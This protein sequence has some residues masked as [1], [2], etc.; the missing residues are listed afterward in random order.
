MGGEIEEEVDGEAKRG[1]EGKEGKV[2][3]EGGGGEAGALD[4]GEDE[5]VGAGKAANQTGHGDEGGVFERE[6]SLSTDGVAVFVEEVM[7]RDGGEEVEMILEIQTEPVGAG[8]AGSPG[9]VVG[10]FDDEGTVGGEEGFEAAEVLFGI[11]EVFEDVP[12]SDDVE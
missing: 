3:D 8:E 2:E 6:G 10:D 4:P 5:V 7:E 1:E 9:L 12:E 11:G